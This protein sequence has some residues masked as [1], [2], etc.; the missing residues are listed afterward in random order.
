MIC[1]PRKGDID[2]RIKAVLDLLSRHVI[3]DDRD[4]VSVTAAWGDVD[5]C[6]VEVEEA[7]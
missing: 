1:G 3:D 4:V 2:N 6:R 7:T 5:G